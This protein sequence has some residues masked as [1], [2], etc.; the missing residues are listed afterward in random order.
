MEGIKPY[1]DYG[2]FRRSAPF[3][4]VAWDTAVTI[5]GEEVHLR[6]SDYVKSLPTSVL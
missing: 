4:P 3:M 1:P 2:P 6:P 5:K